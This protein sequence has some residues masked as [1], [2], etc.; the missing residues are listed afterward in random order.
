MNTLDHVVTNNIK[1]KD[2]C[3]DSIA[4]DPNFGNKFGLSSNSNMDTLPL[5]TVTLRG[6]NKNRV[7]RISGLTCLWYSGATDSIIKKKHTRPYE[8]IM[9]SNKVEYSMVAGPYFMI[10]NVKMPFCMPDFSSSKI[11]LHHFHFDN[12]EGD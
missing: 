4:Y 8:R 10:H 11:I 7:D 5:V 9:N 1:I 2:Q 6:G 3:N 12:D